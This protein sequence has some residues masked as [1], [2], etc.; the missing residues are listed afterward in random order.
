[1]Q[2][3]VETQIELTS[4]DIAVAETLWV[5][6]IQKS[7]SKNPKFEIWKQQFGIFT[8]E[9]G[10]MTCMGSLAQAQLPASAKYPILLDKRHYITCLLVRD[11]HK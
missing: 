9:L 6:E 8:N 11:S 1:L 5:K 4:Q 10:I 7:L 2:K 3:N